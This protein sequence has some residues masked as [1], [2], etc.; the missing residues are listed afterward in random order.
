[1]ESA[2]KRYEC[3]CGV[4]TQAFLP[5][6]IGGHLD[7][8]IHSEYICGKPSGFRESLNALTVRADLAERKLE[9]A[10]KVFSEISSRWLDN[11]HEINCEIHPMD[12]DGPCGCLGMVIREGYAEIEKLK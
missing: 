6:V 11:G 8:I 2:L 9:V 12:D 1:M 7:A 10:A 4:Y 3:A 5:I